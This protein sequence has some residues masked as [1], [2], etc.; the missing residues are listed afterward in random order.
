MREPRVLSVNIGRPVL[1]RV[2]KGRPTGIGKQPVDVITVADPGPKRVEDGSGVSGVEGDHIGDGRHHGGSDQAVY[3][4]AREE[5]DAWAAALG[6]ELPSGIFGE[7]LTTSGLDVDELQRAAP[8]VSG[9]LLGYIAVLP[10]IGRLSDLVSRQRV[11]LW[12]LVLFGLGS[13]VT[14]TAAT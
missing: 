4:F 14:K 3:A 5:L 1:Q 8:I 9:F 2:P 11:L 13:V 6:R 12:C 10:L 7:N